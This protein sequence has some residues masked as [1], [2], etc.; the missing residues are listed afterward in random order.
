MTASRRTNKRIAYG[1]FRKAMRKLYEWARA[2]LDIPMET[3]ITP[4][5][6]MRRARRVKINVLMRLWYQLAHDAAVKARYACYK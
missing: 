3:P 1:A 5:R 4:A 6:L 2:V